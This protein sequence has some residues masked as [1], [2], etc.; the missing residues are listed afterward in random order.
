ML[1]LNSVLDHVNNL[2]QTFQVLFLYSKI[3]D[4]ARG[5]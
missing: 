5:Y 4:A 2:D 3:V 1:Y